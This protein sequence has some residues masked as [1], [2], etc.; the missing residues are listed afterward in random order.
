MTGIKIND[1]RNFLSGLLF[2]AFGAL[3][4]IIALNYPMGTATQMGA[5]YLPFLLGAILVVLGGLIS[6]RSIALASEDRPSAAEDDA[7]LVGKSADIVQS[8]R[9]LIFIT[10]SLIFFALA[11]P[12]LGLLLSVAGVVFISS[13]AEPGL[14]WASTFILALVMAA[15]AAVIFKFGIGLPFQLWP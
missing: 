13:F 1:W 7:T 9:P 2:A 5:G 15:I 10:A 6:L 11:L 8:L 4:A 12:Y 3:T 14:R